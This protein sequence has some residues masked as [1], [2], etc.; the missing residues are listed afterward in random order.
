MKVVSKLWKR[1]STATEDEIHSSVERTQRRK[2]QSCPHIK[3]RQTCF[4]DSNTMINPPVKGGVV[5]LSTSHQPTTIHLGPQK[6]SHQKLGRI[7]KGYGQYP[8]RYRSFIWRTLLELPGNEQAFTTLVSRGVHPEYKNL[9]EKF[10]IKSPRLTRVLEKILSALAYWSDLFAELEYLPMMVFPIVKVFQNNHLVCF[11]IC[12]S[13]LKS[14]CVHWFEFFPNPPIGV[15]S[16]IENIIAD[17]DRHVFHHLVENK[18]TTQTYAW[19]VLQTCRGVQN[20]EKNFLAGFSMQILKT[21]RAP[22]FSEI[23]TKEEW[24]IL[25]DHIFYHRSPLWLLCAVSAYVIICKEPLLRITEFADFEYF[26]RH[27]NAISINLLMKKTQFLYE[28]TIQ[29]HSNTRFS[30][31]YTRPYEA[32][33]TGQYPIFN[34]YPEFVVDYRKKETE[35]I[36]NEQKGQIE[37]KNSTNHVLREIDRVRSEAETWLQQQR[38]LDHATNERRVF[39]QHEQLK[40]NDYGRISLPEDPKIVRPKAQKKIPSTVRFQ[41]D[42][43]GYELDSADLTWETA[44]SKKEFTYDPK[45]AF[46]QVNKTRRDQLN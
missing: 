19:P 23:L 37:G 3:S 28:K 13:M 29:N 32:L 39:L 2:F 42:D 11:E 7:L 36:R 17:N 16:V 5:D 44:D 21:T 6:L 38:A 24:L 14:F 46:A 20:R 27:R 10:Q 31:H 9:A 12:A 18:V 45:E 41:E 40:N 33:T 4:Q 8:E 34:N 35:R 25:F 22:C 15:L 30:R 43:G 1:K 26:F